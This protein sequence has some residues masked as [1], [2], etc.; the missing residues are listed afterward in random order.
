MPYA[1][2]NDLGEIISLQQFPKTEDNE[3]LEPSHPEIVAFT[4]QAAQP[5]DSEQEAI[6][7]I[8]GL[9]HP[10]QNIAKV[11]EDIIALLIEKKAVIFPDLPEAVQNQLLERKRLR[12]LI[13]FGTNGYIF[14][15]C[16]T[17]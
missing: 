1:E 6:D 4:E 7:L 2:R 16:H 14:R 9:S 15:E 17:M 8:Q 10:D 13:A 5:N 12:Q 11:S 3:Y